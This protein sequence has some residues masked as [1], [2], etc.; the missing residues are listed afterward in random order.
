MNPEDPVTA[1]RIWARIEHSGPSEFVAIATAIPEN[2]D[3]S[4]VRVLNESATSR[5][6]ARERARRLVKEMARIVHDNEGRVT[7]VDMG[8]I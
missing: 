6:I 3:P 4:L 7:N 2:G 5:E 1:Y 8:G